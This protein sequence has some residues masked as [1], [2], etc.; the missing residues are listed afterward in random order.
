MSIPM[1]IQCIKN[2]DESCYISD[3]D[4]PTPLALYLSDRP[5]YM[6]FDRLQR[7]VPLASTNNPSC[8]H[9]F[10]TG[11]IRVKVLCINLVQ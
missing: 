11:R 3:Q 2:F 8:I 5:E 6:C 4:Y 9:H 1:H 10:V 7:H